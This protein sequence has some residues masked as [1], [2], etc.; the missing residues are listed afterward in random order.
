MDLDTSVASYGSTTRGGG[1]NVDESG[2]VSPLSPR[3]ARPQ[4]LTTT[5]ILELEG[6]PP[7][8]IAELESPST[9]TFGSARLPGSTSPANANYNDE[10]TLITG[11][12]RPRKSGY[13]LVNTNT[14][15]GGHRTGAEEASVPGPAENPRATLF[16]T[17]HE[18][19]R[20]EHVASWNSYD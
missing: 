18:R 20:G 6:T 16:I 5:P 7:I 17:A 12:K 3:L 14:P 8:P 10:S 13:S 15:S 2:L 9:P 11:W 1:D 19:S 4:V